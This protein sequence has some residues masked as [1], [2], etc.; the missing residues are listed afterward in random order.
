MFVI[1]TKLLF[2]SNSEFDSAYFLREKKFNKKIRISDSVNQFTSF[3]KF[4]V[5]STY[6]DVKPKK[7]NDQ[8]NRVKCSTLS[9]RQWNVLVSARW[10]AIAVVVV[11]AIVVVVYMWA[12]EKKNTRK[13]NRNIFSTKNK[14]GWAK[15]NRVYFV[16]VKAD[17]YIIIVF[18]F[19]TEMFSLFKR[20]NKTVEIKIRAIIIVYFNGV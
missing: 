7:K 6:F 15:Q 10:F 19:N 13:M 3:M 1:I 17:V 12:N 20:E 2:S 11:V 5:R 16:I 8:K 14:F 4:W 9:E 18:F